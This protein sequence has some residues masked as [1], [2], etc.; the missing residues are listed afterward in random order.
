MK[1]KII[2]G[3]IIAVAITAVAVSMVLD[4]QDEDEGEGGEEPASLMAYE[5]LL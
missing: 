2:A 4:D 5:V 1:K 3:I